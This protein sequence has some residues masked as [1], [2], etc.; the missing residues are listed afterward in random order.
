MIMYSVH[1]GSFRVWMFFLCC[2]IPMF[3]FLG[4]G[5]SEIMTEN[6]NLRHIDDVSKEKFSK[7]AE[8]KIY[9]G[10]QSVG[11]NIMDGISDILKEKSYI[12]LNIAETS[13]TANF[14]VPI[15]A[16]SRVGENRNPKSK[17]DDFVNFIKD[18]LGAD[19][20]IAFLKFCY[21]DVDAKSD[22]EK[23]FNEYKTKLSY[24][25]SS[26]P[27]IKFV[28]LTIPLKTVQTGLK[29]PIKKI[30]GKSVTGYDDNIKRN[31]YNELLR[32][33]YLG[34][35]PLFDLAYYE[36]IANDGAQSTFTAKGKTYYFLNPAFTN[37]GGH[38]NEMGRRV[39]A[40]QLLIFLAEL[41][42]R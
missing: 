32:H 12:K 25:K 2:L 28:H 34:K 8:K 42:T 1:V 20:D 27:N 16:H 21:V 31:E 15:F 4:N 10:H 5:E 35:E 24:L 36:S 33:E 6:N 30:L 29:V 17:I 22:I 37:D 11:F 38:L 40:E 13:K 9:F 26:Y 19:L 18:G 14:N 41:V 7:L 39:V 3:F 23:I